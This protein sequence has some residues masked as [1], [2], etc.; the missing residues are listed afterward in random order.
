[1]IN[2]FILIIY[3]NIFVLRFCFFQ[4]LQLVFWE[5]HHYTF[6][7]PLISGLLSVGALLLHKDHIDHQIMLKI[8]CSFLFSLCMYS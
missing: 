3:F 5:F 8:L 1:M 6:Y 7:F 2:K 4:R